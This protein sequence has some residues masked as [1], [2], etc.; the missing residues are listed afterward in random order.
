MTDSLVS[1]VLQKAE[2]GRKL[3]RKYTLVPFATGIRLT[4]VSWRQGR[5]GGRQVP[6]K[7]PGRSSFITFTNLRKE[8]C[9]ERK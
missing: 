8:K 9:D 6:G 1:R 4:A 2:L 5:R 7:V 3:D